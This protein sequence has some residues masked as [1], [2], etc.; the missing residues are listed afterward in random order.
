M[1][2]P[3]YLFPISDESLSIYPC[4]IQLTNISLDIDSSK[5]LKVLSSGIHNIHTY[6]TMNKIGPGFAIDDIGAVVNNRLIPVFCFKA[7]GK[8]VL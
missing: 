7:T 6:S 1:D 3:V 2:V 4:L 5:S 8:H